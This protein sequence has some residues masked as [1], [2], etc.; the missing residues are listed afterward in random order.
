MIRAK[1]VCNQQDINYLEKFVE[2][3]SHRVQE[4]IQNATKLEKLKWQQKS[5]QD[6]EKW[7][8]DLIQLED[9]LKDDIK[10]F[11]YY[12]TLAGN[13]NYCYPFFETAIKI[14]ATRDAIAGMKKFYQGLTVYRDCN[15]KREE[16]NGRNEAGNIL[17]LTCVYFLFGLFCIR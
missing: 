11:S 14:K 1:L 3:S 12:E 17:L 13:T 8:S 4:I 15:S 16:S 5:L 7:T 9:R 2:I 6:I 10:M